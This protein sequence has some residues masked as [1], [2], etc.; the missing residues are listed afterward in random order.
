MKKYI[1]QIIISTFLS[2]VIFVN[3][4]AAN[5]VDE[6]IKTKDPLQQIEI[7]LL[8]S[9]SFGQDTVRLK[10]QLAPLFEYAKRERNIPLEWAYYM[11]MADGFSIAID[12]TNPSSDYYYKLAYELIKDHRYP[13]LEM[14]GLIRQGYYNFVYRKVIEAFP[15]Y[16]KANDLK[17]KVDLQKI[18]LPIKH[19]QFASNFFNYIGDQSTA[20]E[21]LQEVLPYSIRAS[22]ERINLINAIAL[23]NIDIK[24]TAQ[25]IEYFNL[26]MKEAVLAK[27]S[28][29]IGIISG[30]LAQYE[31]ENGDKNKAINLI[32]KNISLSL[33]YAENHDA[34]RANLVLANY[35][36]ELKKYD[37]ALKHIQKS[38][39][40]MEKKPYYLQYEMDAA[41]ALTKIAKGLNNKDEEL[42]QLNLYLV[43]RD[44]LEART[45][46]KEMQKI[47]WNSEREKYNRNIQEV[48]IK[49]EQTIRMVIYIAVFAILIF[50]IIFLLINRSKTRIKIKN[51][52]LEKE[53]LRL[54]YEKQL[55][56]QELLILKDSL[57]D[58]TATIKNND[59]I[60]NELRSNIVTVSK[61][62][63]EGTQAIIEQLNSM[64]ESHIMTDERWLKFKGV[65]DKVYPNYL[66]GMKE[67]YQKLTDNDLKIIAL[68]KLDLNN[69]TMSELLCI[70]LEGIKKAKQRLKKKMDYSISLNVNG[71]K[72]KSKHDNIRLV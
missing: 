51:T 5:T 31:W 59:I 26:A 24:N 64:L 63:P 8:L 2:L 7:A 48:E 9:E 27:D 4:L 38:K 36:I 32:E 14:I 37:L 28:V 70:S 12:N 22:R 60:I 30:N 10:Q 3:Q 71:D 54:K 46:I 21:Y 58:F 55:V 49:R 56:D 18:P 47:I 66:S 68:Q 13:E 17:D 40:L 19:Y 25:M 65:F 29:W 62:N 16:L 43:L 15:Y 53:Q 42:K 23:Y 6:I 72:N 67:K 41:Y 57:E 20:L 45:D 34:M 1:V 69:S 35:Y 44:S 11:E 52:L 50:F 33:R 39:E 61:Q